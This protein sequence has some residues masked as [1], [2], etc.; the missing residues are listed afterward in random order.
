MSAVAVITIVQVDASNP[1]RS[2]ALRDLLVQHG[3]SLFLQPLQCDTVVDSTHDMFDGTADLDIAFSE[4]DSLDAYREIPLLPEYTAL[5]DAG[6]IWEL[7]YKRLRA[8]SAVM[9]RILGF[10]HALAKVLG[11][12]RFNT[13]PTDAPTR[14]VPLAIRGHIGKVSLAD[15]RQHIGGDDQPFHMLN[16]MKNNPDPEIPKRAKRYAKA[17]FSFAIDNGISGQEGGVPLD[18]QTGEK[19]DRFDKYLRARPC[20]DRSLVL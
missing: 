1:E 7:P 3:G 2:Q 13:E 11:K 20:P 9:P 14:F 8:M 10:L 18:P 16:L 6:P 5:R 19:W 12:T 4:H 17:F 15:S